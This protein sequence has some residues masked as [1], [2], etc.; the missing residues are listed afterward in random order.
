E[1]A[2]V[3]ALQT[4][5]EGIMIL[6]H[7]EWF[8]GSIIDVTKEYGRR[9]YE[10]TELYASVYKAAFRDAFAHKRKRKPVA[11]VFNE[12]ATYYLHERGHNLG[13]VYGLIKALECL[14]V[15][16]DVVPET[17]LSAAELEGRRV[18]LVPS[19]GASLHPDKLRLL[20]EWAA[21]T[22]GARLI[23]DA[24]DYWKRRASD[25]SLAGRVVVAGERLG[26]RL[27]EA[28]D[29][30]WRR[31][32]VPVSQLRY[33]EQLL[34]AAVGKDE[35]W[36]ERDR[37][38]S[39]YEVAR[40][41][42]V[43]AGNTAVV[44]AAN[45]IPYSYLVHC[46]EHPTRAAGEYFADTTCPWQREK[47]VIKVALP[48][49]RVP[50]QVQ[51]LD[52]DAAPWPSTR[53]PSGFFTWEYDAA[54]NVVSISTKCKFHALFAIV[55]GQAALRPEAAQIYPGG[56]VTLRV[57]ITNHDSRRPLVG[58]L[59]AAG[60]P[61]LKIEPAKVKVGPR[62][63]ATVGLKMTAGPDCAVGK[64]TLR[65]ELKTTDGAAV[66]WVPLQVSEPALLGL[67]TS[68]IAVVR[69][70]PRQAVL[71]VGNVG[72]QPA[73]NVT[74]RVGKATSSIPVLKARQDATVSLTVKASTL[75]P[76]VPL[77]DELSW[78]AARPPRENGL[79]LLSGADGVVAYKEQAGALGVTPDPEQP[80]NNVFI[81]FAVDK[82]R[83]G[84]GDYAAE[85]EIEY[86][87]AAGSFIIEYDSAFGD[88][89]EDRYHDS[90]RVSLNG[91][92][93]WKT[94]VID[95]ER[96]RFA[97]RQ[98]LG[99]DFRISGRLLVRRVVLRPAQRRARIS[100]LP[101]EL[102]WRCGAGR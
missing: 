14:S 68:T 76:S 29:A 2:W 59:T 73:T 15:D 8:E 99:A 93:R 6:T 24:T 35:L 90:R 27:S 91:T 42:V 84:P 34:L 47:V 78:E 72:K 67:K 66:C 56:S 9:P 92:G 22:P 16:F 41:P 44:T 1:F 83:V 54:T 97:G 36:P 37:P 69:E 63:R 5:P 46:T 21:R 57:Q 52:S 60:P 101:V 94:V 51:L 20:A 71:V 96:A 26:R 89:I 4:L 18:V 48:S 88:E 50:R 28:F 85:A 38:S 12:W 61:D 80:P 25:P 64:R 11:V 79:R 74:I 77:P 100:D 39:S 33:F 70:E 3:K 30:A 40:G 19:C 55:T 23:V 43:W 10:A 87:D 98:N 75:E 86:F 62:Q 102:S 81:Y 82:S 32:Q 13:D 17:Y 45:T 49:G 31:Q 53:D 7:S 95:L 58:T 65:L